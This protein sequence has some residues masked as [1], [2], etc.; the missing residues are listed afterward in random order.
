MKLLPHPVLSLG[1]ALTWMVLTS[2]SLGQLLMGTLVGIVAARA[3]AVLTPDRAR[4]RRP[5]LILRLLAIVIRD[6][7]ES[8][9]AVARLIL[10]GDRKSGRRSGFLRIPLDLREPNGL[11]LLALIVTATPG[12]AWFDHDP[13]TGVLLLHVF[14]LKE[15]ADWTATIKTRYESLLLE[16]FQ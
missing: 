4:M 11:G 12:T 8:N 15:G 16:I 6:I 3:Y 7:A 9:I 1:L 5:D 2:F 13:D 10:K 14:D